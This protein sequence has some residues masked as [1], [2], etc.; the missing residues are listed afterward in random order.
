MIVGP[1]DCLR[2]CLRH[3]PVRAP[4]ETLPLFSSRPSPA[5]QNSSKPCDIPTRWEDVAGNSSSA[6][7]AWTFM[8]QLR[9]AAVRHEFHRTL[10]ERDDA[11]SRLAY[12]GIASRFSEGG[13]HANRRSSV[14]A[15]T[16][17]GTR[18]A[19]MQANA[20]HVTPASTKG[21]RIRWGRVSV[22][23]VLTMFWIMIIWSG[24]H[25]LHVV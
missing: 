12:M 13:N 15:P 14:S 10:E 20:A 11:Y 3:R 9:R 19:L 25:I 8:L 18:M 5:G 7:A 2:H 22:L 23:G 17:E 16:R 21:I 1:E 6:P 4:W 24:L